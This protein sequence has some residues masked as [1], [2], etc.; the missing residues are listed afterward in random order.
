MRMKLGFF[1]AYVQQKKMKKEIYSLMLSPY[2]GSDSDLFKRISEHSAFLEVVNRNAEAFQAL[3][4]I[5]ENIDSIREMNTTISEASTFLRN[6]LKD[7]ATPLKSDFSTDAAVLRGIE[8][9]IDKLRNLST[10]CSALKVIS[11]HKIS[12]VLASF[13]N[14][15]FDDGE[16]LRLWNYAWLSAQLESEIASNK[17]IS[18][19]AST[20]DTSIKTFAEL[21]RKHLDGNA[22][23]ILTAL[24]SRANQIPAG[25]ARILSQEAGKTRAWKPFRKL[26][27]EMPKSIQILKP[28]MAMSPLAVSQLLPSQ[29]GLFDVVIFDEASQIRPHDAVTAIYRGKQVVIAGDRF[30][31]PPTE[32]GEKIIEDEY[33]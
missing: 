1:A 7:S 16:M 33:I 24:S 28:V 2:T 32:L 21:D 3:G 27:Q 23:K 12:P 18:L 8:A 4:Y 31:L 15:E 26:L 19:S 30:Q 20:L 6:S 5:L 25:D 13:D 11:D 14:C 10:I 17:E 9:K 22:G 29:A